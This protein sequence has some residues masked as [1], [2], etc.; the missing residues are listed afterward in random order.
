MHQKWAVA[1]MLTP[2]MRQT[3]QIHSRI[4]VQLDAGAFWGLRSNRRR[5]GSIQLQFGSCTAKVGAAP[6]ATMRK[7]EIPLLHVY[8]RGRLIDRSISKPNPNF[9][10]PQLDDDRRGARRRHS[11]ESA[12][13]CCCIHLRRSQS[14]GWERS[15]KPRERMKTLFG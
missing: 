7:H 2:F 12:Q 14:K 4:K 9:A 15:A 3:N 6:A 10:S 13:I 8:T 11:F 1:R 5:S